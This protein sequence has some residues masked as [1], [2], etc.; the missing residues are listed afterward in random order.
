[1]WCRVTNS[2]EKIKIDSPTITFERNGDIYLFSAV[3]LFIDKRDLKFSPSKGFYFKIFI[4]NTKWLNSKNNLFA[5]GYDLR[6]FLP[7]KIGVLC[8]QI[9]M[10]FQFGSLPCYKKVYCGG[11]S[12]VRGWEPGSKAGRHRFTA[13]TEFRIPILKIKSRKFFKWQVSYG[14]YLSLIHI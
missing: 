3:N 14:Y 9:T 10:K 11:G 1:M 5:M 7:V 4:E 6:N 2:L 13:S 8:N 12:T